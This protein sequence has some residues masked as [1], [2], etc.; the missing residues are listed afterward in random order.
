VS[1][2]AAAS[3]LTGRGS[4]PCCLWTCLHHTSRWLYWHDSSVFETDHAY[5][6][7]LTIVWFYYEVSFFVILLLCL[8]FPWSDHTLPH[9]DIPLQTLSDTV[10]KKLPGF[11]NL[12]DFRIWL[13]WRLK[14]VEMIVGW[15]CKRYSNALLRWK[16]SSY[17]RT[18]SV[19]L[20]YILAMFS[21][22]KIGIVLLTDFK[23]FRWRKL[24]NHWGA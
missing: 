22:S 13:V 20:R 19:P 6:Q 4:S 9:I 3:V 17:T 24:P 5:C 21:A 16:S 23:S 18:W 12:P 1:H 8:N 15:S 10:H 7:E 11:D 2:D 14:L